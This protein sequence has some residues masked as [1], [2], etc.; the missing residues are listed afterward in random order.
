MYR[1]WIRSWVAGGGWRLV[2]AARRNSRVRIDVASGLVGD[3]G[4][5][6]PYPSMKSTRI[7]RGSKMWSA[8]L[9]LY[10]GYKDQ[11]RLQYRY[12]YQY[13]EDV[14]ACSM[15]IPMDQS[16]ERGEGR[17]ERGGGSRTAKWKMHARWKWRMVSE[18]VSG[19]ENCSNSSH[20]AN[21]QSMPRKP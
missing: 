1:L 6:S 9:P 3:D 16:M 8:G 11:Q 12:Q 5:H 2:K 20:L 7:Q 17:G 13:S 18:W 19:T 4:C 14:S 21:E 10:T 15:E